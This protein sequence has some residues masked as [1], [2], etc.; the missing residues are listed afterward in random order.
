MAIKAQ[1]A[2]QHEATNDEGPERHFARR[3]NQ[4]WRLAGAKV[5]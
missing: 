5:V 1:S 3:Q 2:A 4:Q